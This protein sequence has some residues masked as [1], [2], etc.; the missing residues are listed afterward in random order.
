MIKSVVEKISAKQSSLSGN[1]QVT[2]AFL[3]DSVTQGCF[4]LTET[5]DMS[6]DTTSLKS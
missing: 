2:I 4:E 1:A 3:G 6:F 5:G